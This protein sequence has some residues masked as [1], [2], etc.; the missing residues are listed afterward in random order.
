MIALLLASAL[1][2]PLLCSSQ[3][4]S[5]QGAP[6]INNG[7]IDTAAVRDRARWPRLVLDI[8]PFGNLRG[9]AWPQVPVLIHKFNPRAQ[10]L[11]YVQ[12]NCVWF[13]PGSLPAPSFN[14]DY[15]NCLM[16]FNAWL[17]S[18]NG[19]LRDEW[20]VN[21]GNK[22][23]ADSMT[24]LLLR[25]KALKIW[26][27]L[28]LDSWCQAIEW[29]TE[30]PN[31]AIDYAR[32]GFANVQQMDSARVVNMS[33][34]VSKLRAAGVTVW[35]NSGLERIAHTDGDVREGFDAG[36]TSPAQAVDWVRTPG[37]HWL[38]AEY[39][40]AQYSAE[41]C[42]IARFVLGVSCLGT[43][44]SSAALGPDRGPAGWYDEY[45]VDASN[46]ADLTGANTGWLGAGLDTVQV[47]PGVWLRWFEHGAVI[48]NTTGSSQFVW[49]WLQLFR[50][51]GTR[52]PVNNSGQSGT[53]F[54]VPARDALFLKRPTVTAVAGPGG[55]PSRFMARATPNPARGD[56]AI[57]YTLPADAEVTVRMFDPSGRVV[58]TLLD[59]AKQPAGEH[60]VA[61]RDGRLAPGQ[62]F[63]R[64]RAGEL[65]TEG[66]LV[67]LR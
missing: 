19:A 20:N 41:A 36:L 29:T 47:A 10:V 28:F 58:A 8:A 63:Y 39:Y 21:W 25:Q 32:A 62:Y 55:L 49:T 24:K 34:V 53:Y 51:K 9:T 3:S 13:T 18:P 50:I 48:V 54:V 35:T 7:S 64:V 61:V 44:G 46:R 43:D 23:F 52:D 5:S 42:R 57:E 6:L 15:Y 45:S 1:S 56:G 33:A 16:H 67:V 12:T 22:A 26:D 27:G 30:G 66:R 4:N 60:R 65:E 38:K 2:F 11:G 31:S 17:Y 59:G 37:N 40:G 14:Q